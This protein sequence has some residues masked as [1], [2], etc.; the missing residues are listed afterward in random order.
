MTWQILSGFKFISGLNVKFKNGDSNSDTLFD[1]FFVFFFSNQKFLWVLIEKQ[2]RKWPVLRLF[3]SSTKL[4]PA[5]TAWVTFNLYPWR[6]A[7]LRVRQD[8]HSKSWSSAYLWSFQWL[9]QWHSSDKGC[10]LH[11]LHFSPLPIYSHN[12]WLTIWMAITHFG[13]NLLK[14]W[15]IF[16]HCD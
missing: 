12:S 1:L 13:L 7:V 14:L 11:T 9:D 2:S 6:A 10:R 3:R 4:P 15:Q 16:T 8:Y 5:E